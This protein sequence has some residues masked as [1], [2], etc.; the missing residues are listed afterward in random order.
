M[1]AMQAP[2]SSELIELWQA[3]EL[4]EQ[5]PQPWRPGPVRVQDNGRREC[6]DL[7][8]DVLGALE[9]GCEDDE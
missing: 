6:I 7:Q 4:V 2:T 5:R 9:L 1:G 3:P 8:H